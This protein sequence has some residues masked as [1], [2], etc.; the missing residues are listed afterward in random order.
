MD[1][2]SAYSAADK[3]LVKKVLAGDNQAFGEII[4]NAEGLVAMIVFKMVANS[5]DHKDMVQD[6]YL[7]AFDKLSGFQF[8]SKLSTWIGQI[9]YHTCLHYLEKKKLLLLD[10]VDNSTDSDEQTLE[11]ISKRSIDLFRNEPETLLI[12]KELKEILAFEIDQLPPV[13]KTL[14]T[15]YQQELSNEE[16]MQISG[17][18][19]GT[20][21]SYLFRARKMLK[22]NILTK[23]KREEL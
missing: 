6:I 21:K 18:P 2:H 16:M 12:K 15:L 17:L 14:I 1:H 7:K 5:A 10:Q 22:E 20:I 8:R 4:K 23:Y 11:Q 19:E 9:A 13:Y 3:K